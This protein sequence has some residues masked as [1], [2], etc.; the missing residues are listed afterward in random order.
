MAD[1]IV[2][3]LAQAPVFILAQVEKYVPDKFRDLERQL[4]QLAKWADWL[5]LWLDCDREG[6]NICFEVCEV[7]KRRS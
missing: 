2:R 1:A 3:L 7:G 4:K 5:V 6:E